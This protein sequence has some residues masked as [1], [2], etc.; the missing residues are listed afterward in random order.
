MSSIKTI[1]QCWNCKGTGIHGGGTI[2]EVPCGYCGADGTAD[3][4]PLII[5]TTELT[6]KL[7]SIIAEQ[8]AQRVDLTAA[9]TNI[10]NKVKDL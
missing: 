6:N 4:F 1:M 2:P 3:T 7:D 9:L 5:D 8:A 10:W